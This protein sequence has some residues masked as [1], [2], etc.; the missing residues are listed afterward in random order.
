[1]KH[2]KDFRQIFEDVKESNTNHPTMLFTDVVGSSK[3]WTNDPDK[4]DKDLTKHFKLMNEISDNHNGFV[5]KTI[6][7]AFMVYFEPGDSLL[8]AI[9]SAIEILKKE[10]LSLRIGICYG[11][12]KEKTFNIQGSELK[13][14]FGNTINTASRMESK[15]S[16]PGEFSFC[17]LDGVS[18]R[19]SEEITE[20]IEDYEFEKIEFTSNCSKEEKEDMRGKRSARILSDIQIH[21]CKDVSKLEGIKELT[22]FKV[23][24]K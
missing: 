5:V 24:V 8:N 13:D 9:K 22:A 18:E 6:G 20:L 19:E 2:L 15:V 16:G 4:M 21:S 1:M 14:Y 7:D 10:E 3:L 12:M 17:Y 11:E 23:K